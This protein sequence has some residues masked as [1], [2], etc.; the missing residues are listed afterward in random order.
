MSA[1]GN[2]FIVTDYI[3]DHMWLSSHM[4]EMTHLRNSSHGGT[5][6]LLLCQKLL[7][8][9]RV[10]TPSTMWSGDGF[11]KFKTDGP[12]AVWVIHWDQLQVLQIF[13]IATL[14]EK[15]E[16][17]WWCTGGSL[18][19]LLV[20]CGLSE[21]DLFWSLS[22]SLQLWWPLYCWLQWAG[23]GNTTAA[24]LA[25]VALLYGTFEGEWK[26]PS[27]SLFKLGK[28]LLIHIME[29]ACCLNVWNINSQ[30]N[31]ACL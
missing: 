21:R 28:V 9:S 24:I 13:S 31:T 3:G 15:S 26:F 18:F 19:A 6:S 25:L 10:A 17:G 14:D 16:V 29:K 1:A 4:M 23:V 22:F 2:S 12:S 8:E 30:F 11:R 7:L 5:A 20:A 27:P